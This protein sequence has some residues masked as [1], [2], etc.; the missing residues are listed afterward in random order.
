MVSGA[1]AFG[2]QLGYVSSISKD[3]IVPFLLAKLSGG[4]FGIILA[5]LI[6]GIGEREN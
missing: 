2:G 5:N 1:F 3:M 4:I 6:I